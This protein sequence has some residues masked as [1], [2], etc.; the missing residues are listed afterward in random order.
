MFSRAIFLAEK[1]SLPIQSTNTLFAPSR[2][3]RTRPTSEGSSDV[4]VLVA[5]ETFNGRLKNFSVLAEKFS[6]GH[7][8][9]KCIFEAVCVITQYEIEN[10]HPLFDV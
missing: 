1:R 10:G 2:T 3:L 7:E 4:L 6:H 9:H 5:H 8:K